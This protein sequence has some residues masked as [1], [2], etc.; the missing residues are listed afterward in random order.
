MPRDKPNLMKVYEITTLASKGFFWDLVQAISLQGGTAALPE[1]LPDVET[2]ELL[3][4]YY[5]FVHSGD[6]IPSKIL[7]L[8]YDEEQGISET[9]R[10][11]IAAS[12]WGIMKEQLLRL[13]EIYTAEYD[14]LSPYDVHE[15]TD[16]THGNISTVEDD[17]TVETGYGGSTTD[18][19]TAHNVTANIYG[20]DSGNTP[21]GDTTGTED[22]TVTHTFNQRIDTKT[23]DT[24]KTSRDNSTD[25]LDT[26]KYGTLGT[27][28]IGDL[29]GREIETWKWNFY[30]GT[31]FPAV[32]KM[33]TIPIY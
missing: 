4:R 3:D 18:Q 31:L 28:P 27:M 33:L 1:F 29:L 10:V 9:N 22:Y 24:T 11:E 7:R 25:D 23:L 21:V 30:L 5:Y 14:P 12:F 20:F 15:E 13:W 17:G 6:K 16:Y 32:D 19:M 2:A 26:H 8:N